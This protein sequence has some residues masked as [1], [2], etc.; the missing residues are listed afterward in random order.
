MEQNEAIKD[1]IQQ[2]CWQG[3]NFIKI[4]EYNDSN[5]SWFFLIGMHFFKCCEN[6]ALSENSLP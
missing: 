1:T 5:S 6:N 3:D 2:R 4:Y